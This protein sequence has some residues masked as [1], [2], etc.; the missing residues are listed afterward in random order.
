MVVN[1]DFNLLAR[2]HDEFVDGVVDNFL[3]EHVNAVVRALS[4]A[5]FTDVHTGAQTDV[6]MPL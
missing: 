4:V 3:D 5:K 2:T 6:F 1:V